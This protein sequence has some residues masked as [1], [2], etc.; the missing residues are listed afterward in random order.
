MSQTKVEI[1]IFGTRQ[2]CY[3]VLKKLN[4]LLEKLEDENRG[5]GDPTVSFSM[6]KVVYFDREYFEK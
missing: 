1:Q 5:H 2:K 4:A 6:H 3:P